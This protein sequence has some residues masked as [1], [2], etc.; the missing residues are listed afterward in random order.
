MSNLTVGRVGRFV[1][2]QVWAIREEMLDTIVEI[3]RMR[4]AGITLSADEV[5]ARI[6]AGP[7]AAASTR[8][9]IGVLPLQGVIGPKLNMFM[10]ISGG[11]SLELFMKD[12]RALRDDPNVRAILCDIDSPGGSV[13]MLPEAWAEIY[14]A[15]EVKLLVAMVRPQCGSAALFI[16]SAFG[17][18]VCT[19][20]GEIGSLGCYCVHEDWSEANAQMGVKPT[21]ISYGKH[22]VEGNPDEP[23]GDEARAH[24][25]EMVTTFG[26]DF[27]KHV[28]KGRG[29]SLTHVREQFGQG[30]M[31]TAP[32][33]KAAGLVDRVA[34]FEATLARLAGSRRS[35]SAAAAATQ[36]DVAEIRAE[37]PTTETA[38]QSD[39]C[40][41]CKGS[42]LQP[43]RFMSGPQGQ[44]PCEAC[45]GSGKA[46]AETAP[47]SE[48]DEA[49]ILTEAV[50]AGLTEVEKTRMRLELVR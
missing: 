3:V 37:E 20:S 4:A 45:G 30:R 27:E 11:T 21:Y 16:A 29:V 38:E 1:N 44:L 46:Q 28:A 43:E 49:A 2:R 19:P 14:A 41:A 26:H 10:E 25:Q 18:I 40:T 22:K 17:E 35:T 8:D 34:T 9:T 5:R 50:V 24:L 31:L 39:V 42:G 6:G 23:L 7:V 12:F 15:R 47:T 32:Q 48:P 13:Y 33:A 36:V